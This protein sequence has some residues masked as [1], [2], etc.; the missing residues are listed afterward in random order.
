MNTKYF[1]ASGPTYPEVKDH[2]FDQYVSPAYDDET[3]LSGE[4]LGEGFA[5]LAARDGEISR[6]SLR[7]ELFAYILD[8]ARIDVDPVDWFADHFDHA[9]QIMRRHREGWR[10]EHSDGILATDAK[11]LRR[12]AR[13]GS[14]SAELDLGHISP[15]WRFLLEEGAAG[16]LRILEEKLQGDCDET[17]R[18][19]YTAA[20]CTYLAFV[21]FMARLETQARKMALLHPEASDRMEKLA[22]CLHNL[23]IGPPATFYEALEFAYLYHQ[24]IEFEGENVRSMGSFEL[25]FGRFYEAD[26]AAGRITEEDA[27]E[28]IRFFWL[29]FYSN[30]RGSGNGKNFYFGGLTDDETDNV[31]PLSYLAMELFYE[32]NLPDPKLS[33]KFNRKTPEAFRRLIARCLRD[34]RTNMVIVNDEETLEAVRG[35][36]VSYEDSFRYLLIGCYEPAIEGK[37]IA[38]NMCIKVNLAKPVE[39]V[40]HRGVDPLTG[41]RIGPD[42]GDCE[43]FADF[44]AFYQA[45][46]MQLTHQVELVQDAIRHYEGCWDQ[47]NP[48]PFLSATFPPCLENGRDISQYGA[49]YNNTGAMGGGLA[50]A[51]DSLTA[52]RQTVYEEKRYTFEQLKT[53]LQQ[54]FRDFARDR[55]YLLHRVPKWGNNAEAADEMAARIT[56]SYT[57]RTNGVPNQ[58]GGIYTASMFTLDYCFSLGHHTGA[59]PDGREEGHY[60]AKG[61]GAMTG[62]DRAGV[63]AQITSVSK[64]DFHKIPNGS[65]LDLY[66]HP[67]AVDGEKGIDTLLQL[68]DT[69]FNRG[70][71]GVQFNI[72]NADDLRRAQKHPEEYATLQ[73]RVCGWNVY[74]V[75]LNEEQQ[76][77]F[78]ETTMQLV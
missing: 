8:H 75:T 48:E 20:R 46:E 37:E 29:K 47:I 31:G 70:G 17:A 23:Q 72:L 50:N 68:I 38:C 61:I 49:A 14:F 2:L 73:V 52:I 32:L 35:R 60:I 5:A 30:T 39:L 40:L 22:V 74:F 21:R 65:V 27:R 76:N 54:N 18:E 63:T 57:S 24:L 56:E 44:D 19:F 71:Y 62:M 36:G 10:Q 15:G 34:G 26:L 4:A 59:L 78:I 45:Y 33:V 77:H 69:Y 6:L 28:L 42:T 25:N 51:A 9:D 13:T 64:L 43:T 16:I 12:G 11:T 66:L 1:T 67:S 58:R 55:L 3:G 41:E 53:M 7:A